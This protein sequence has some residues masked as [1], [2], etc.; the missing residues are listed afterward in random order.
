M[1]FLFLTDE[2]YPRFGANS[3]IVKTIS[4][5]LV[6]KGNEVFVAPFNYPEEAPKTEEWQGIKIV[7]GVPADSKSNFFTTVKKLKLLTAFKLG[8]VI[9][10]Q[11]LLGPN[12]LRHKQRLLARGFLENLINQNEIDVVVSI[13]CS[14]EVGFPILYLK[15][16]NR[17]KAK[18]VFYMLDPFE[19]HEYYRSHHSVK[20]LR[21]V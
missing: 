7:R 17:I 18:W 1:K 21:K 9:L 5:Q 20:F 10:L 4:E 3:L 6:K 15:R 19:S 2:F 12:N 11:K 8:F 13:N 14:V 16:K